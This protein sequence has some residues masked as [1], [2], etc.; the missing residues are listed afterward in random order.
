MT[1]SR[2]SVHLS[3]PAT[4]SSSKSPKYLLLFLASVGA[5]LATQMSAQNSL[6]SPAAFDVAIKNGVVYDGT[7][8]EGR[9]VDVAL[10]G[11][12]FAA[13]GDFKN[14]PAKLVID[15]RGLAIAP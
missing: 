11:D 3:E 1:R 13:V 12:R 4:P 8:G 2:S 5:M 14:A 9:A 15:A 7:G 6:P 10:R